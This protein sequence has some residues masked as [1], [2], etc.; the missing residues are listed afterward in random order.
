MGRLEDQIAVLKRNRNA[1]IR[2]PFGHR[3]MLSQPIS[4]DRATAA[5]ADSGVGGDGQ[6]YEV[7]GR[8]PV[9][10]FYIAFATSDVV[11]ATDFYGTLFDWD[12]Q[13]GHV[14]GGG[15]VANTK[16]PMG[17][18]TRDGLGEDMETP[19]VVYFR[20]DDLDFYLERVNS[21]GGRVLERHDYESGPNARCVDDQ[22]L[23][24]EIS[25]PAPGY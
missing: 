9:E 12:L 24:F 19:S 6:K 5:E 7:T 22:G 11:K 10:P 1:V 18:A 21:L 23:I 14:Q 20:V 25:Q 3:W 4:D 2:D 16:F 13:P 17:F 15:H 8:T